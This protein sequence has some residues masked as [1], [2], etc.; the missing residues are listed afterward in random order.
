VL[1]TDR[2]DRTGGPGD[3]PPLKAVGPMQSA[4]VTEEPGTLDEFGLRRVLVVLGVPTV[5]GVLAA[6]G[7]GR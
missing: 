3:R 6:A 4:Q 1:R 7:G 5:A 2:A